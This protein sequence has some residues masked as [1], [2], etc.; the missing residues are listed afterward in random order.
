MTGASF[1]M[2]DSVLCGKQIAPHRSGR[3]IEVTAGVHGIL[4]GAAE[5]ELLRNSAPGRILQ[6]GFYF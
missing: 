3:P 2:R 6:Y 1:Q 4:V 5:I